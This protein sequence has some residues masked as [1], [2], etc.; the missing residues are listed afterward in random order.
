MLVIFFRT[1]LIKMHEKGGAV[2]ICSPS[3]SLTFD[4]NRQLAP[5]RELMGGPPLGSRLRVAV[6]DVTPGEINIAC[7]SQPPR[8]GRR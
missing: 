3:G 2:R 8:E 6:V 4:P 5:R 7:R 1:D